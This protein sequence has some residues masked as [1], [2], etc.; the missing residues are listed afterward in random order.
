MSK[1]CYLVN[2]AGR[3]REGGDV[4]PYPS[5]AVPDRMEC[6]DAGFVESVR[7]S[8]RREAMMLVRRK[9]P[10]RLVLEKVLKL[11]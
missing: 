3:R 9:Y 10:D 8:N 4:A 11:R 1:S 6:D 7:A 5:S 2:V